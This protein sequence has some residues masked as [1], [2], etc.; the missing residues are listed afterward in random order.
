METLAR[1]VQEA[2]EAS[3]EPTLVAL[4]RSQRHLPWFLPYAAARAQLMARRATTSRLIF[5]DTLVYAAI[6]P[7]L[8]RSSPPTTVMVHGL[9]MTFPSRPY[10][11]LVRSALPN[12]DRVVANSQSTA[13]IATALGVDPARC[14]VLNPGLKVP[15]QWGESRDD[16]R[17]NLLHRYRLPSETVVLVTLGRLVERK[18]VR[19]FVTEV[20]PELPEYVT[21]LVAGSGPQ[22]EPIRAA[23]NRSGL[24]QRVKLLGP[25]DDDT[26]SLLFAGCDAL[27]MPNVPVPGDVEGFGLVAIEAAMSGALVIA[28]RLEGVVDA[29]V[30]GETGVLCEPLDADSW[31]EQILTVAAD[32]SAAHRAADGF[33]ATARTRSSLTRMAADLPAA[34]GLTS[35]G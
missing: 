35:R 5:G 15:D 25:V 7:T 14:V 17:N 12:A 29:V 20:L 9:D 22:A 2:L 30:D 21:L 11:A 33:A 19:W 18:G 28:S 32:V 23:V 8:P 13:E 31:R 1:S 24:R 16:A 34:L 6:R 10:Q 4:G 27:I 3:A 26:R